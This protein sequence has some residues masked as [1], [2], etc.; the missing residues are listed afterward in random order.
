MS[1]DALTLPYETT[2]QS[3]QVALPSKV[4]GVD[5]PMGNQIPLIRTGQSTP[6]ILYA[7]GS[8]SVPI[9]QI[10]PKKISERAQKSS[11]EIAREAAIVKLKAAGIRVAS[12]HVPE[13]AKELTELERKSLGRVP[14]GA[15]TTTQIIDEDRGDV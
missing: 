3:K 7:Y 8:S 6:P 14:S 12:V 11:L 2:Y 9:P 13:G 4:T 5:T 10:G 1:N 15:P